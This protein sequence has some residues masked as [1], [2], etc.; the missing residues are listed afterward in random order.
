M[1]RLLENVTSKA[2]ISTTSPLFFTLHRT[3]EITE[4]T[5][6]ILTAERKTTELRLVKIIMPMW[7]NSL[8]FI[9]VLRGT[10][11]HINYKLFNPSLYQPKPK[12]WIC[13]TFFQYFPV[14]LQYV[15]CCLLFKDE[16]T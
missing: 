2:Q 8:I 4:I 1:S 14:N 11:L 13:A 12:Q 6:C 3:I 15:V 7:N 16:S 5:K 10:A 9:L